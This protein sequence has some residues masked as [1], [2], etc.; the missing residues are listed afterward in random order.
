MRALACRPT[1]FF[2]PSAGPNSKIGFNTYAMWGLCVV[3]IGV[4]YVIEQRD[5]ANDT[6]SKKLPGDVQ[7]VL[8]SGA[9][10]MRD[11]S[12]KKAESN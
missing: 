7:R 3:V 12:I 4:C 8:P 9:W 1:M 10:L 6:G 11:G 5:L 2:P